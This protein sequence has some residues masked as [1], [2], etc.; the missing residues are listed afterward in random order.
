MDRGTGLP[1]ESTDTAALVL[2]G[3][4]PVTRGELRSLAD[5]LYRTLHQNAIDRVLVCSDNPVD[6]LRAIDACNR[7]GCDLWIAH[8]TTAPAYLEKIQEQFAIQL[9]I[10]GEDRLVAGAIQV[11][12]RPA[13]FINLMTSGTTGLPKVASHTLETLIGRIRGQAG[14]A[15]NQEGRWLLTYQPTAF[16]GLQV[17]LTAVHSGGVIV[18]PP[19][20]TIADFYEAACRYGVTRISGTPTFWRSFLLVAKPGTLSLRQ[21]TLGGEAIDQPTLDR[22]KAAFPQARVTHIYASTEAGV[23]FAVH[24]GL[25]GFPS[26]WLDRAVQGVQIRIRNGAIEVKTR[27]AMRRYVSETPQ[28]LT[29]DGWIVTSDLA[30]ISPDRVRILG[31]QDSIINVG[32]AKVYPQAVESFLLG[33]DGVTEAR[34]S[35][36]PNP[37]TGYLVGAEVVLAKGLEVAS[38]RAR[39]L[40]R[41]RE[42]LASYQVPRILKVVDSVRAQASGKK[43]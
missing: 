33:I 32:G 16:A 13:G 25:E 21:V 20:R 11:A 3:A 37:I 7:K 9:V 29:E 1:I 30:E 23:I 18:A 22:V 15:A 12:E 17:I 36:I 2:G 6:I 8:T 5:R 40:N 4:E 19:R 28:P 27:H 34:V 39:I 24:D 35:G 42:G 26:D 10:A 41:C 38:A 14:I 43:G 31:R